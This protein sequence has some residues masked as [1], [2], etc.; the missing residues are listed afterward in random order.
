MGFES[1]KI[2]ISSER[3]G[4]K[5]VCERELGGSMPCFFEHFTKAVGPLELLVGLKHRDKG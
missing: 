3:R 1:T 2:N 4:G 5:Y